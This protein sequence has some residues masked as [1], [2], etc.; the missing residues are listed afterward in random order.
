[1]V[2]SVSVAGECGSQCGRMGLPEILTLV[3]AGRGICLVPAVVALQHPRAGISYVGGSD[4]YPAIVSIAWHTD[5]RPAVQAF[6]D[7][8]R[9]IA[10][11][12]DA[13]PVSPGRE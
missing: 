2:W 9:Q 6:L 10:R 1:V 13:S 3:A 11:A 4:A 8:T 12:A 7:T 5:P